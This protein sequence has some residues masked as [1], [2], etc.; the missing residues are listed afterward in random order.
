M[1]G[2][3]WVQDRS[4]CNK[5]QEKPE[6]EKWKMKW[7][8]SIMILDLGSL[9]QVITLGISSLTT[10]L[11]SRKGKERWGYL[12]GFLSLPI[13]C[14]LEIYYKE[15]IFLAST[16]FFVVWWLRGLRNNWSVKNGK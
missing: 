2:G 16:P 7:W 8:E 3:T 6:Q 11:L 4:E 5:A 9:L 13:W 15:W 1:D 14:C 10:W 12:V